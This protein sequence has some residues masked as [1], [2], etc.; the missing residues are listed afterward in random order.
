MLYAESI[1]RQNTCTCVDGKWV[2]ARPCRGGIIS[3]M[4]DAWAVVTG[5]ADAVRFVGQ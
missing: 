3:R 2:L 5:K 1:R 4:R